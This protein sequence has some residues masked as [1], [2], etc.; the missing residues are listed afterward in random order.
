MPVLQ[1][2]KAIVTFIV[3]CIPSSQVG[4][5]GVVMAEQDDLVEAKARFDPKMVKMAK[6]GEKSED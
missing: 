3:T 4:Q 6:G 1:D 2:D 5:M